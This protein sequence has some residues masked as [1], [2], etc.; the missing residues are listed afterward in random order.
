MIAN[1]S[2]K[3]KCCY[4]NNNCS[5]CNVDGIKVTCDSM[6]D[7]THVYG[8]GLAAE[9]EILNILKKELEVLIDKKRG[10]N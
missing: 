4:Q 5:D 6:N 2:K 7:L 3:L 9:H 10:V 1:Y 8:P